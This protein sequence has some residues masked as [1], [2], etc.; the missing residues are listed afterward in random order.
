MTY[1]NYFRNDW[2]DQYCRKMSRENTR[3]EYMKRKQHEQRKV[4]P[5]ETLRQPSTTSPP[6]HSMVP[7]DA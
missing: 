5:D 7:A 4:Q 2:Y 6:D 1:W 3:V